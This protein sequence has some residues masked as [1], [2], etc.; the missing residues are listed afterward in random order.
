MALS[1]AWAVQRDHLRTRDPCPTLRSTPASAPIR[2]VAAAVGR[3]SGTLLPTWHR[4][5][6][7]GDRRPDPRER[8]DQ[9]EPCP[10]RSASSRNA[11]RSAWPTA[12]SSATPTREPGSSPSQR[13]SRG[14]EPA[15]LSDVA[16]VPSTRKSRVKDGEAVD[17]EGEPGIMTSRRQAGQHATVIDPMCQRANAHKHPPSEPTICRSVRISSWNGRRL[18]PSASPASGRLNARSGTSRVPTVPPPPRP[19]GTAPPELRFSLRRRAGAGRVPVAGARPAFVLAQVSVRRM[20][21]TAIRCSPSGGVGAVDLNL[22]LFTRAR[23][24][25]RSMRR[26]RRRL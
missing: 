23:A 4:A 17:G 25:R 21:R 24:R 9:R 12:C 2:R 14:P 8:Q 3:I 13:S 20:P 15:S 7:N 16:A 18:T 5:R 22:R 19:S 1:S 10:M 26:S 11:P 6:A